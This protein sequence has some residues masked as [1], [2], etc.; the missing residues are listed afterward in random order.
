MM[1]FNY[2]NPVFFE[3]YIVGSTYI[4]DEVLLYDSK[5]SI[6]GTNYDILVFG[7]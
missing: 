5:G 7:C 1:E 4:D 3:K 2:I 6:F